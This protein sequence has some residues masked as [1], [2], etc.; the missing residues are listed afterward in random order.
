MV[1]V[2]KYQNMKAI[3]QSNESKPFLTVDEAVVS[4][5]RY[6]YQHLVR[7]STS[8]NLCLASLAP[9]IFRH[10]SMWRA[11]ACYLRLTSCRLIGSADVQL[12]PFGRKN[13]HERQSGRRTLPALNSVAE[14]RMT[15]GKSRTMGCS[16]D[17]RSLRCDRL[18]VP[19]SIAEDGAAACWSDS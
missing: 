6:F 19:S 8:G 2:R 1:D 3:N 7:T 17:F 15:S 18:V 16:E 11:V 9:P 4:D 10:P 5:R 13:D 14:G 12:P